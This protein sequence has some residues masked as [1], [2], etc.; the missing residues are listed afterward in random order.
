MTEDEKLAA[1]DHS[2]R[3]YLRL[4]Q[5]D[6]AMKAMHRVRHNDTENSPECWVDLES[7]YVSLY[8]H[9][10]G[11]WVEGHRESYSMSRV[12]L[13]IHSDKPFDYTNPETG[14]KMD[15]C[16]KH[17]LCLFPGC[18]NPDHLFWGTHREHMTER[19]PWKVSKRRRK[20]L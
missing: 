8:W 16:H 20:R 17:D 1:L 12:S 6:T 19:K 14:R 9:A 15:A 10:T 7:D 11:K 5:W 18:I 2:S 3:E 13:W 4:K